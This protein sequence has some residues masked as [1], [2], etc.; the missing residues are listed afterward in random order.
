MLYIIAQDGIAGFREDMFTETLIG[1]IN[2]Y[3]DM[4]ETGNYLQAI[5]AAYMKNLDDS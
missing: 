4:N 2:H 5:M 1:T 3:D